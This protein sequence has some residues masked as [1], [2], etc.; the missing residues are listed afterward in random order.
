MI[1]LSYFLLFI[2]A[3]SLALWSCTSNKKS[4][5]KNL[6]SNL[7]E[8][9]IMNKQVQLLDVRSAEEYSINRIAG[10]INI[11]VNSDTFIEHTQEILDKKREV[12][13]YCKSGRRSRKAANE[14]AK[15]GYKVYNLDKGI[16]GWVE[17]G[18]YIETGKEY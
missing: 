14:L 1:K 15:Q 10:S 11:D 16:S 18:K 17:D 3:F 8:D 4:N 7:F 13:V 6:S 12:A 2:C 5:Y 9:L